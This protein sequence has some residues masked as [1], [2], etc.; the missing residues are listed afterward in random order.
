MLDW[1]IHHGN[2]IQDTTYDDPN[3]FYVSIHRG[4]F[5][6]DEE[7][8][9]NKQGEVAAPWFYPATGHCDE[10][11]KGAG[12]GTNLN[13]VW[14]VGGMRNQE[15]AAAFAEIVLPVASAFKPDLI[16][17]A[18]GLDAAKGDTLGDC[19]L[20]PDM[21]Y[22]MT[23][24]LLETVG[25][26]IPFVAALEGGYDLDTISVCMEAVSLS[27]LDE[28]YWKAAHVMEAGVPGNKDYYASDTSESQTFF[29][30]EMTLSRYW[31]R[32]SPEHIDSKRKRKNLQLA[33]TAIKK[34]VRALASKGTALGKSLFK[35]NPDTT[36]LGYRFHYASQE[37]SGTTAFLPRNNRPCQ[38]KASEVT[39]NGDENMYLPPKKRR[40]ILEM[41]A[42]SKLLAITRK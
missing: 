41:E 16:I 35:A 1:D 24:S 8:R 25:E 13:I 7:A 9:I 4:G 22:I 36:L 39:D 19:G 40:L 5:D 31:N 17:I 34:S 33:L 23:N 27:L 15:Y 42:V 2:G 20:T 21:F 18:C 32:D 38:L 29:P 37:S 28:P 30:H 14:P 26:E 6:S 3:I 12:I 10:T 11:G